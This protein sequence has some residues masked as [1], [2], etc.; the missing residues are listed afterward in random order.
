MRQ[1]PHV[2]TARPQEWDQALI[3]LFR[4]LGEAERIDRVRLAQQLLQRGELD[5][6][7]LFVVRRPRLAGVLLCHPA[8]GACGLVWPPQTVT[9]DS[10]LE[11]ALVRHAGDWLRQRGCKIGQCLLAPEEHALAAPLQRSGF[12]HVTDLWYFRHDLEI[13]FPW[14]TA[15]DRLH[16]QP[17]TEAA[18]ELFRRVLLRTYEGTRDCPEI[19]G[20]RSVDEILQ[21]H[22]SQGVF[23]PERWCLAHDGEEPI[24]LILLA[25]VPEAE[26]WDVAYV[27][28]VPEAR[29]QGFGRDMLLHALRS[30]HTAGVAQVT[31]S[32]DGRN[33]PAWNLYTSL[34][35]RP[36]EKRHVYLAVWR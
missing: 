31:L 24:G 30:A 20:V 32:V 18:A 25:E 22:R 13:P 5:P 10:A 34:G 14:L 29:R 35:F 19:N 4:H 27:G 36:V 7:G 23:D 15:A 26:A 28:V 9:A 1:A 33:Q 21:G 8:P 2:D 17:Y 6:A 3:L 16:Y 11:D 12:P